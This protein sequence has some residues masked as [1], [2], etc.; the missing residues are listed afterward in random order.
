LEYKKIKNAHLTFNRTKPKEACKKQVVG[1]NG[2]ADYLECS[3]STTNEEAK[4]DIGIQPKKIKIFNFSYAITFHA[5]YS[6][7]YRK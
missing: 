5:K 3:K 7:K 4:R 6:I 1:V 2:I